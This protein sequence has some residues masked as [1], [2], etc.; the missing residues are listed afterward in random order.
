MSAAIFDFLIGL[1]PHSSPE[2]ALEIGLQQGNK[3][4]VHVSDLPWFALH[5]VEDLEHWWSVS[6][7]LD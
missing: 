4:R 2:A 5:R 3:I 1:P 6:S 7:A